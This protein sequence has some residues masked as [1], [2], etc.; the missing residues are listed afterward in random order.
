MSP[1]GDEE[2]GYFPDSSDEWIELDRLREIIGEIERL[3]GRAITP[4]DLLNRLGIDEADFEML[5]Q[6]R[7]IAAASGRPPFIPGADD[8]HEPGRRTI[9]RPR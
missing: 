4:V 3:G 9:R 7:I 1:P 8:P 6:A 5:R 2:R